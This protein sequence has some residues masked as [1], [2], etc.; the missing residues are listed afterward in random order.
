[1]APAHQVKA[2]VA[3]Q[4]LRYRGLA[5]VAVAAPEVQGTL[6][7]AQEHKQEKQA[8]RAETDYR[9][10]S[11]VAYNGMQVEA[12]VAQ[13]DLVE[14]DSAEQVVVAEGGLTGINALHN[15]E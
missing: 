1:V 5:V 15:Q 14:L 4:A 9:F 3:G 8:A 12:A 6:V 13:K 2:L 10:Q 11:L 7:S